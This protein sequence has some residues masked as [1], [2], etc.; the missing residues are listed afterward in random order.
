MPAPAVYVLVVVG[1]VATSV[2]FL[3]VISLLTGFKFAY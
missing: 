3:K 2:A 1:T